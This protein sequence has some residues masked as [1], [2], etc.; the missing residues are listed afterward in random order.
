MRS[1]ATLIK[2]VTAPE[3]SLMILMMA[4][5]CLMEEVDV[6]LGVFAPPANPATDVVIRRLLVNNE[7]CRLKV[8]TSVDN[9]WKN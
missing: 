5:L 7:Q 9:L 2:V 1:A 4:Y 8:E 3:L 6:A